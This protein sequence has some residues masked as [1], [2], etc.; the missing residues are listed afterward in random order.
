MTNNQAQTILAATKLGD[1]GGHEEAI[2]ISQLSRD[3]LGPLKAR[4]PFL[5][6][7]IPAVHKAVLTFKEID[8]SESASGPSP[9]IVTRKTRVTTESYT[10]TLPDGILDDDGELL[11]E[12]DEEATF[13]IL[14]VFPFLGLGLPAELDDNDSN[15]DELAQ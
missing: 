2:D 14:D 13:D 10:S 12:D 9:S 8:L 4:D 7:S 11:P 15:D 5:Y 1:Q 6:H 3:D